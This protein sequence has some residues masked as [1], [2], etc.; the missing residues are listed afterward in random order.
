MR[1]TQWIIATAALLCVAPA[2][3]DV[4]QAIH[5]RQHDGCHAPSAPSG[6]GEGQ[7][8]S[9]RHDPDKCW[10]CVQS[11]AIK[12]LLPGP[13][14]HTVFMTGPVQEAACPRDLL[15]A[16]IVFLPSSPRAPPSV[17]L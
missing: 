7:Q 15:P 2:N 9:G 12:T 4:L 10:F 1:Q 5:M 14:Q 11:G 8:S 13:A 16:A 3:T 17:S 6:A